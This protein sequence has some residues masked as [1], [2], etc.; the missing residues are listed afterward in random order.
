MSDKK[1]II[2]GLSVCMS[3]FDVDDCKDCP[4]KDGSY[5]RNG[6][7]RKLMHDIYVLLKEQNKE[8]R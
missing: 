2:K 3:A 8:D 4:Y 6:C 5:Y 7:E 1:K